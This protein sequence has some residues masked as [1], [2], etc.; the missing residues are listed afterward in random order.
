MSDEKE[1]QLSETTGGATPASAV[2]LIKCKEWGTDTPRTGNATK[3]CAICK[4][5]RK[6]EKDKTAGNTRDEKEA[7]ASYV[8]DSKTKPKK[9]QPKKILP[10]RRSKNHIFDSSYNFHLI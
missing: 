10:P 7:A 8:Y 9:P 4:E 5:R 2:K 6:K 1:N 3:Y